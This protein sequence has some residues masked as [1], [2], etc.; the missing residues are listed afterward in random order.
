[1]RNILASIIIVSLTGCAASIGDTRKGVSQE[2][3]ELELTIRETDKAFHERM[4][5]ISF[6][7]ICN[8]MS[9]NEMMM[10]ANGDR[11]WIDQLMTNCADRAYPRSK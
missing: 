11:R 5:R 1:M 7:H 3:D 6:A 8:S 9:Y 4:D 10:L 2:L